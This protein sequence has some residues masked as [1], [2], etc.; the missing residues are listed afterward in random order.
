MTTPSISMSLHNATSEIEMSTGTDTDLVEESKE[1]CPG[2]KIRE[3][4]LNKLIEILIDSFGLY[5][6]SLPLPHKLTG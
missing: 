4:K 5:I 1:V 2:I 3:A 6:L